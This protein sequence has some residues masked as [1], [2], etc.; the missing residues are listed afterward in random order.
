MK[1]AWWKFSLFGFNIW[2][3]ISFQRTQ[4]FWMVEQLSIHTLPAG[5]L[6]FLGQ[7]ILLCPFNIYNS[8]LCIASY[9][10]RPNSFEDTNRNKIHVEHK[11]ILHELRFVLFCKHFSPVDISK[12][13][14]KKCSDQ[15]YWLACKWNHQ[16]IRARRS[17]L[18]PGVCMKVIFKSW[19]T[20]GFPFSALRDSCLTLHGSLVALS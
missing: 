14:H 19:V 6:D 18:D 2:G 8:C 16:P 15:S 3:E 4:N 12:I 13:Y 7:L 17:G 9:V 20:T 11:R 1:F 10:A 5:R